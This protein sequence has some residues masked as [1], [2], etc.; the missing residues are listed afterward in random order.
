MEP[1]VGIFP[2]RSAAERAV[3]AGGR[4]GSLLRSHGLLIGAVGIFAGI[5]MSTEEALM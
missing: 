5:T 4:I 1:V 3:A 2:S